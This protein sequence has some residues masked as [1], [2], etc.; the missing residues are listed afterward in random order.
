MWFSQGCL[1]TQTFSWLKIDGS[2]YHVFFLYLGTLKNITDD[3]FTHF[4]EKHRHCSAIK[5]TGLTLEVT[6]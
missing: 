6:E 5:A 2:L 4:Y 1:Q 3:V